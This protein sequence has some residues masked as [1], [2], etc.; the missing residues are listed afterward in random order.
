MPRW[1]SCP[2][3]ASCR[4]MISHPWWWGPA[5]FQFWHSR[6]KCRAPISKKPGAF[7]R[8]R[9]PPDRPRRL[10]R[11]RPPKRRIS[12]ASGTDLSYTVTSDVMKRALATSVVAN[13]LSVLFLCPLV[14]CASTANDHSVTHDCCH[15]SHSQP[16]PCPSKTSPDCFYSILEKSKTSSAAIHWHWAIS[17][18]PAQ[19]SGSLPLSSHAARAAYRLVNSAGLFLRN[20]VLLI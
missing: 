19:L 7:W 18:L 4:R 3:T 20:R 11:K 12:L 16:A 17:A 5:R 10:K 8:K 15:K 6:C 13:L 14:I 9:K 1:R 2:F